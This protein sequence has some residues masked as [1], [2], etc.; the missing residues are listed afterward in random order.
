MTIEELCEEKTRF[1]KSVSE[2]ARCFK[3]KTGLDIISV[4]IDEIQDYGPCDTPSGIAHYS[5]WAKATVK[6]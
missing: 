2:L 6:L 4:E 1:E 3:D 5:T